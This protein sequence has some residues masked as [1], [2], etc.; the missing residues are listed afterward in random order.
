MSDVEP[1]HPT[2]GAGI[3]GSGRPKWGLF[4]AALL[5]TIAIYGVAFAQNAPD[6][7][8][9]GGSVPGVEMGKGVPTV[10]ALFMTSKYIN[11]AI[12]ALSVIALLL[13]LF[14]LLTLTSG[15]FNPPR[16]VDDVTKLI[17]NRNF[18][19]ATHLCQQRS[20]IFSS[21]IIQRLIENRDKELGVLME[22]LSAEGRRR[23]EVIWNR[24]GYLAEISNIAPMLGLLGTVVGMI[25]VFFTLTER[26]AGPNVGALSAGI[27]EAMS[28]TMFGLIVAIAAGV[29]YTIIRSRATAAL[30]EAEQV[31]HTIA[32]HT[33]RA[34][35]DPRLKKIDAL[36]EAARQKLAT[37][38]SGGTA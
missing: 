8:A 25:K 21:S 14:L 15:S 29:F 20:H 1:I 3:S 35:S 7:A 11:G 33:H 26:I 27:A 38:Q 30:T 19:Q 28:T 23:S 5:L 17:L 6:A 32:D 37:R 2:G 9:A 12:L 4:A 18:E 24:V 13:F 36:A 22:I 16:F 34:A 10:W 31:C